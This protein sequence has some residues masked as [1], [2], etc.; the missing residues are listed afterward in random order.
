M[1]EIHSV[2]QASNNNLSE[3]HTV[4]PKFKA[5]LCSSSTHPE[6]DVLESRFCTAHFFSL[7]QSFRSQKHSTHWKIC[8]APSDL[9]SRN[10]FEFGTL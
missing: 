3:I 4:A 1:T 5:V 9:R 2:G 6:C 8:E 7:M 10:A